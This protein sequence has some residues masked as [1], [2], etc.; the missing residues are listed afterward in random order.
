[1]T[2]KDHVSC[3]TGKHHLDPKKDPCLTSLEKI[4]GPWKMGWSA[5]ILDTGWSGNGALTKV[6]G[7]GKKT[8]TLRYPDETT[9]DYSHRSIKENHQLKLDGRFLYAG[10]LAGNEIPEGQRFVTREKVSEIYQAIKQNNSGSQIV[11]L[12]E[13]GTELD[14]DKIDVIPYFN[15]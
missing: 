6:V 8:V 11:L 12:D 1:M 10:E 15:G 3:K 2:N 9:Y 13:E 4:I 5:Y 14:F 7:V